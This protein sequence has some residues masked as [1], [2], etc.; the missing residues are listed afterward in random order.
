MTESLPDQEAAR[1][2]RRR[3]IVAGL[4]FFAAILNYIDRNVLSILAPTIQEALGLTDAAY[5]GV[6]N[7]FLAAYTAA[8]LLSGRVVDWLGTRLS[9]VLFIGWWSLANAATAL[10]RGPLSL[11]AIRAMLGLG[12]A[13]G[14][15]VSPKVVQ[16]WFPPAERGLAIGIYSMGGSVGATVAPLVVIPIALHYSWHW[17]FVI[18]GALGFVW[19][20]LWL[21][22]APRQRISSGPPPGAGGEWELWKAVLRQPAVRSFTLARLLTDSVWYFY[23]FWFPKYLHSARGVSQDGLQIMWVIFLAADLGFL[24][25]GFLSG[26]FIKRGTAPPAARLRIMLL[27]ACLVPVSPLVAIVPSTAWVLALASVVALAHAAW[28]GNISALI[29]DII[30]PRIMA[31]TFGVIAAGSAAGGI[32]MNSLVTWMVRD[33]SYAPCF[34]VMA[35]LHPIAIGLLWRYRRPPA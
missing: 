22:I 26:R 12:E 7:A 4:L 1:P 24:L 20:A 11:G 28:L 15:T 34:F 21:A 33:F 27:A 23:L 9:F 8:Y 17:A 2:S 31:T 35:L 32:A 18:T 29:V 16:E 6:L 19:I 25:G 10:A 13:G 5:A 30:P 14:W 3:W